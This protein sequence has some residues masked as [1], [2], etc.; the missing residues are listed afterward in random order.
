[1]ELWFLRSNKLTQTSGCND[2]R[3][4][5]GLDSSGYWSY[6]ILLV[7][8]K[9][10]ENQ[11]KTESPV[12]VIIWVFPTFLTV[13]FLKISKRIST[14]WTRF[15]LITYFCRVPLILRHLNG[16]IELSLHSLLEILH[17]DLN[18]IHLSLNIIQL[19]RLNQHWFH[20]F[21]LTIELDPV[22]DRWHVVLILW[23]IVQFFIYFWIF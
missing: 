13:N 17:S 20:F 5:N 10:L 18:Q 19:S 22:T 9:F 1:M 8:I 14:F 11:F 23:V 3:R 15:L 7:L 4:R 2:L 12:L 6:H 21:S 16:F